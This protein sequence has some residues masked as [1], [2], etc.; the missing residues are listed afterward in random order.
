MKKFYTL[1]LCVNS[2]LIFS[3]NNQ[4]GSKSEQENFSY[5]LTKTDSVAIPIDFKDYFSSDQT[6]VYTQADSTYLYRE[7]FINNAIDVYNWTSRKKNKTIVYEQEGP[8]AVKRFG[9]GAILPLSKDSI[10]IG[11]LQG[12]I[13]YTVND[14]VVFYKRP[15]NLDIVMY[16]P[17][18][19]TQNNPE[20]KNRPLLASYNLSNEEIKVLNIEYPEKFKE[21][22]W[23]EQ[24]MVV[25]FTKNEKNQLIVSFASVPDIYVYDLNTDKVIRKESVKSNYID[26]VDPYEECDFNDVERYFTYLKSVGKYQSIEYDKYRD[27]YYRIINLP[28]EGDPNGQRNQDIVMP[29]SIM[30][31][32]KDFNILTEKKFPARKYDPNDY[33]ITE[34]GLWISRN[35]EG[36]PDFNENR[37]KYDLFIP[38]E[39]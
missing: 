4:T 10:F 30:M 36:A 14:S 12:N 7:N 26:Q 22:C 38:S 1:L 39:K 11:N 21:H 29:F 15:E 35:N 8:N 2:L 33:F 18:D 20:F 25:P 16:L 24:H 23:S 17:S 9:G 19:Y 3:C 28:Q 34:K 27:L 31:L 37:I 13:Y 6:Q 5:E 32:D